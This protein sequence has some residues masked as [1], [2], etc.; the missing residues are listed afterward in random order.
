[1]IISSEE[2]AAVII[3]EKN[4]TN[5]GK[6]EADGWE[7]IITRYHPSFINV[8]ASLAFTRALLFTPIS[9]ERKQVSSARDF[10]P[11]LM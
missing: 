2:N 1:M 5:H 9:L 7:K 4:G 11:E 10:L 6:F 3:V 8:F